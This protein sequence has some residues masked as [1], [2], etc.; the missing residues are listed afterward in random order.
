M[1]SYHIWKSLA[2]SDVG[3]VAGISMLRSAFFYPKK[4]EE[5]EEQK[6]KMIEIRNAGIYGFSHDASLIQEMHISPNAA[7]VDGYEILAPAIDTDKTTH[8]LTSLVCDKGVHLVTEE[9]ESDLLTIE[10]S[11]C[12]RFNADAIINC[13]GLASRMLAADEMCY[14]LLGG[15]LRYINESI[16]VPELQHALTV[17]ADA[18]PEGEIIF[19]VP[20]N[21]KILIVGGFAE[22]DQWDLD[23]SVDSDT[24]HRM[25]ERAVAFLPTLKDAQLDPEYPFAQGLRPA[26]KGNVRLER[27]KRDGKSKIVHSYGHGGSGWSFSFGCA[28]EVAEI[29]EDMVAE[30]QGTKAG[31]C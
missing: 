12:S 22:P 28:V 21:D 1:V 29:V 23:H 3:Q 19:I 10:K 30:A 14:P 5:D 17:S 26:R 2:E 15:L 25:Q 24:V 7:I 4:L 31:E 20:R 13:S 6:Q 8:W 16:A 27:E 9:I 18:D 11:L